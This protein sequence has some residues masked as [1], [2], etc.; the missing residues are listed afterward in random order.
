MNFIES[1]LKNKALVKTIT[2]RLLTIIKNFLLGWWLGDWTVG[3]AFS[4]FGIVFGSAAYWVHEWMWD[5]VRAR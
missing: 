5:Q 2:W 1:A 3:L 4:V